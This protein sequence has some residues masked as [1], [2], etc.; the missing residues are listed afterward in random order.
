[1]WIMGFCIPMSVRSITKRKT[2]LPAVLWRITW[3]SIKLF[4]LGFFFGNKG[5][6]PSHIHIHIIII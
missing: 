3:R 5:V 2:P 6:L 1:M 4:A